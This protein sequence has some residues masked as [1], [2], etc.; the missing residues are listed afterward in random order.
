LGGCGARMS[1]C[2]GVVKRRRGGGGWTEERMADGLERSTSDD[3]EKGGGQGRQFR[4]GCRMVRSHSREP[5][6]AAAAAAAM[7]LQR[8]PARWRDKW[9]LGV[10][11]ARS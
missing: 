9:V 4:N 5:L 10:S 11:S 2:H 6:K 7:A 1:V 3:H 8:L